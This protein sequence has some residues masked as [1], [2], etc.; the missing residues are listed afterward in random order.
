MAVFDLVFFVVFF[1]T[2]L[3]KRAFSIPKKLVPQRVLSLSSRGGL[4]LRQPS[5]KTSVF[6]YFN[7]R[8]LGCSSRRKDAMTKQNF[9]AYFLACK[10]TV[11]R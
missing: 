3:Q 5:P 11:E 1:A 9:V 6:L 2:P 4:I 7:G 10:R 8:F